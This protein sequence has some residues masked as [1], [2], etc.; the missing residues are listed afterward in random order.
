MQILLLNPVDVSHIFELVVDFVSYGLNF[1]ML[2]FTLLRILLGLLGLW[3]VVT[4]EFWLDQPD[5]IEC[6]LDQICLDFQIQR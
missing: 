4:S 2:A 3:L 5:Q 1:G 6:I